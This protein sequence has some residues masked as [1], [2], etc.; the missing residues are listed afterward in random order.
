VEVHIVSAPTAIYGVRNG[1]DVDNLEETTDAEIDAFLNNVRRARGPLDPG[2]QYEMRANAMWLHTRPDFAKLHMRV[3]DAWHSQGVDP[4]IAASSFAN[5]HTYINQGWLIGIENCTRGLQRRGVTRAQLLEGIMHAQMSGGMRGLECVYQA[6]G[7]ILGDYV[8]RPEPAEWPEGWAPDMPAFY[9][10]LDPT[11]RE[12]TSQDKRNL[13]DWYERTL[14]WIPPRVAFLAKH[15]PRTLK[16]TRARWEGCFR[17][18][19]PKQMMPYFM[20][21]HNTVIGNKSGLREAVLLAK[22]WGMTHNY[23]VNTII[24]G[25]Y[26]YTGMEQLDLVEEAVGDL[27]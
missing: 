5:L 12:F 17:G 11:T 2:P 21:R 24:Q 9:C 27:L 25:A 10:G 7:I 4:I 26:Y 22:A 1:L 20:L 13:E 6:L 3:L 23:I 8:E 14:G 16:A 19:L 15:D 18:A